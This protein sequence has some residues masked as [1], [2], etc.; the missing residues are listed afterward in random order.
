MRYPK[1]FTFTFA[2][3]GGQVHEKTIEFD[4]SMSRS[5]EAFVSGALWQARRKYGNGESK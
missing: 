2:D 3:E 4:K 1:T 5:A